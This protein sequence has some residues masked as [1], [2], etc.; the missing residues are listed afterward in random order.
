MKDQSVL[1]VIAPS[2]LPLNADGSVYHLHLH[3]SQLADRIVLVGD[4][5]RVETVSQYFDRVEVKVQ[6]RE[7][8]THTGFLNGERIS[9]ISTG[10]G[11]DNIDI[12]LTELDALANVDLTTRQVKKEHKSLEL[13][14]IGTSGSL[15][16]D[17]PLGG[18]CA[19]T[20][21]LGLDGL[22]NYYAADESLFDRDLEEA[23]CR[24]LQLPPRLARPYVVPC[25]EDLMQRIG[26][27]MLQ[28]IT[29]TAPGFF[30]PQGREVRLPNTVPQQNDR[31]ASF[32]DGKHRVSNLEME[33]AALYG[34]GRSL[35]HKTLTV[36]LLIANRADK[37]FCEDYHPKMQ[38][39]IKTVLE[40]W[41]S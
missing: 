33:T 38:T 7:L 5:G 39:L 9:V 35:G 29:A 16:H 31:L 34:M 30:G 25:S 15:R 14:R 32:S 13:I 28:G 6:N 8:L 22:M 11:T 1:P 41:V 10:M 27:D 19:S 4:P 40:R 20:H 2:E 3:P 23:I 24:H 36:C 18:F 17:F 26:Y 21:G 37:T 12:V